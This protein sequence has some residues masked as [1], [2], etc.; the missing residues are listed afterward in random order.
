MTSRDDILALVRSGRLRI[1]DESAPFRDRYRELDVGTAGLLDEIFR[2]PGDEQSDDSD[3]TS[4]GSGLDND[5]SPDGDG[6]VNDEGTT[7]M[8][9][10]LRAEPDTE[11]ST[12]GLT[13][14]S[15]ES[16]VPTSDTVVQERSTVRTEQKDDPGKTESETDQG[17]RDTPGPD[18]PDN[19][20][21]SGSSPESDVDGR[22]TSTDVHH[23][24]QGLFSTPWD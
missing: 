11:S 4:S 17:E 22:G 14:G 23:G 3:A 1:Y 16:P 12:E 15:S 7:T 2:E 13:S 21:E 10:E 18:A 20:S 6:P 24:A 5:P 8:E 9:S 19:G